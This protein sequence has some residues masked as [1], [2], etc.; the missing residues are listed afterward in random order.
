MVFRQE[1]IFLDH[2]IQ[3]STNHKEWKLRTSATRKLPDLINEFDKIAGY[4]INI[5][6]S[7]VFLYTNN[8][9]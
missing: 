5:Q 3:K 8:I 7:A 9:H 2:K 6:K 1:R 4:K